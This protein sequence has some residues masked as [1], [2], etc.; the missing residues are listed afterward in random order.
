MVNTPAPKAKSQAPASGTVVENKLSNQEALNR[1]LAGA[2]GIPLEQLYLR[3]GY[4]N[5]VADF[6]KWKCDGCDPELDIWPTIT[7][8]AAQ[9]KTIRGPR[10]FHDAIIDARDMRLSC[11][12]SQAEIR[13]RMEAQVFAFYDV[14]WWIEDLGPNPKEPGCKIPPDILQKFAPK[15][16]AATH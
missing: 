10:Y 13:Q 16:H 14:G 15:N 1:R 2:L 4:A 7:K 3:G 5:F 12:P 6:Y 11:L 9:G 8:L